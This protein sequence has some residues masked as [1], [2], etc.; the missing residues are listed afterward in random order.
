MEWPLPNPTAVR[1]AVRALCDADADLSRL[2]LSYLQADRE[3][4]ARLLYQTPRP[5]GDLSLIMAS[6]VKPANGERLERQLNLSYLDPRRR[7]SGATR[8]AFYCPELHLLFQ[9]FPVDRRLPGL[10]AAAD[11]AHML[12]I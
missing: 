7:Q 2:E 6:R 11:G 3:G 4:A 9:A 5:D 8:V 1:D 12:P 10:P